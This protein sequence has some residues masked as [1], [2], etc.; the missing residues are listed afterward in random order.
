MGDLELPFPL[1]RYKFLSQFCFA[2]RDGGLDVA[3][4]HRLP[5]F[6]PQ[7]HF[8]VFL[9]GRALLQLLRPRCAQDEGAINEGLQV[10]AHLVTA[11]GRALGPLG[12]AGDKTA[13]IPLGNQLS[14]HLGQRPVLWLSRFTGK[15]EERAE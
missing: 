10:V 7:R 12:Q 14:A 5:H 4:L 13:I 2:D 15:S 1:L 8:H 9:Y 3:L 11:L 6:Q